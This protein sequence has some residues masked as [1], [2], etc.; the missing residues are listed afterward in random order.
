MEGLTLAGKS[1]LVTGGAGGLGQRI[2][3]D[4][5]DLGARVIVADIDE[6]GAEEVAST[7]DGASAAT[8]DLTDP[9]S[10]QDLIDGVGALD[11][12][13]NNAGWDRVEPFVKNDPSV[14]DRLIGINLRA[15]IQLTHGLLPGMIERGFGRVLYV[16][17]DAGR[18]GSSGEAVYSAC[19]AGLIGLSKTI[20]RET[21]RTGVTCNTVCPGPMDTPMLREVAG[22]S[23]KL[24]AALERAIPVGRLGTPYD[25][26]GMIAYLCSERAAYITGQ[27][28]SVSGG[29]SM[30]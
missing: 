5:T 26:A 20:A 8:M 11:V 24:V 14:W 21:A 25:V 28:V 4:L 9:G 3:R 10:V 17:S 15:P 19:K 1:A 29:L 7:L 30:S 27:T 22:E 12:F 13:V 16:S 6:A 18:V 23:P 2:C